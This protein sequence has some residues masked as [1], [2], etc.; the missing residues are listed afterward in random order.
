MKKALALAMAALL[1]TSA[2]AETLDIGDKG[3]RVLLVQ[4]SLYEKGYLEVDPDGMYGEMTADAVREFQK[5]NGLEV[6]GT[7]DETTNEM[8]LATGD[9][10]VRAAQEKLI[11]LGYLTGEADGEMGAATYG[12]LGVFQRDNNLTVTGEL[13]EATV[14]LLM[15]ET[16]PEAETATET[17]TE[18]EPETE[19]EAEEEASDEPKSEVTLVQ[20]RLIELGY[21]QGEADG[22]YG[23]MTWEALVAFQKA[24]DLNDEGD[25][26]EATKEVLFSENARADEIRPVQAR[27]I[28]LG[29][30]EGEAD[31]YFGSMTSDALYAFQEA[32]GL[33][34]TGEINEATKE[35]LFAEAA[36]SDDV[37]IAQARLIELGYLT[38]SADG[39]FGPKSLTAVKRF[40]TM[41]GLEVTG[42]LDEATLEAMM[43]EDVAKVRPSLAHDAK[44]DAVKE[45]QQRLIMFG[46]LNTGAD[47][48][49]GENTENAV[50]LFQQHLEKQGL[51]E[52][53][54]IEAT[55]VATSETQEILF[56]KDYSSWLKDVKLGDEDFEVQRVER[57]LRNLGYMDAQPNK[58]MDEYA[59][60]CVKAVQ[61]AAGLTVTG[62]A[63]KATMDVLFSEDAPKAEYYVARDIAF[64]DEGNVV[65]DV[66]AA[67]ARMGMLSG[68]ADGEY[69]DGVEAAVERMYE[70]LSEHNPEYAYHFEARGMI[71][72]AAQ[73]VLRSDD[74]EV[75]IED[76]DEDAS[77][78]EIS[79]AQRRLHNLMYLR[80]GGVDGDYGK[81]TRNAIEEFQENNDLPVTGVADEATQRVLYSDSAI[82]DWSPYK[83]EVDISRQRVYAF[84]LNEDGQYEK[85]H[86]FIC[87]TGVGNTTP[88]GTFI[89]TTEPL[90]R[91]HYFYNFDCWA[92]YAW[93]ITGPYYFHSVIYSQ[94][95]E[96][97]IRMSSVYNLGSKA[98]H[99]CVRLEVEAAR[100]IYEH[101]EAGTIVEIY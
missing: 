49:F 21:L 26:D 76:I 73:E 17:E 39:I 41:N 29:Y 81:G 11:E 47:G 88:T 80:S 100:W 87:S 43:S 97:T 78:S 18:T 52:E 70:F 74:L 86:E 99:G 101:C 77:V 9:A 58:T 57:Q 90:D 10:E 20:E 91:W 94:R 2:C 48:H 63:D 37:R 93:R 72:A 15:A 51:A 45:L 34:T 25:I 61:T 16:E 4:E 8:I 33:E 7:V 31:G 85:I 83:L 12:A 68:S 13:D 75:Y 28:Q 64:G 69:G 14:A 35:A 60:D 30:M 24:H 1:C 44:G 79:R 55:G 84:E 96:D 23:P 40:Q 67:L 95:D 42:D 92:Q 53:M 50:S 36:K 38:G 22:D 19:P 46:F 6:T 71:T 5:D 32:N 3:G 89:E 62:V 59:V 27:L 66:Q 82:G 54:G 98:S 56:G 65:K